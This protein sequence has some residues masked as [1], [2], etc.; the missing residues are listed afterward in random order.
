MHLSIKL[1]HVILMNMKFKSQPSEK[2]LRGRERAWSEVRVKWRGNGSLC[3]GKKS[4]AVFFIYILLLWAQR[5]VL[6]GLQ[7]RDR[8]V[9]PLWIWM[10]FICVIDQR[11][12]GFGVTWVTESVTW[13]VWISISTDKLTPVTC[14][15]YEQVPWATDS[16]VHSSTS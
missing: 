4:F 16:S 7:I 2:K 12:S 10:K 14:W 9:G 1:S 3:I 13:R 11:E 6:S 15:F 5:K 8:I